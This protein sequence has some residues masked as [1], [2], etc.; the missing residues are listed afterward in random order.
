MS[1][2]FHNYWFIAFI[3]VDDKLHIWR[4]DF[5]T[6]YDAN[7]FCK[8]AYEAKGLPYVIVG[9]DTLSDANYAHI[10]AEAMKLTGDTRF[11]QRADHTLPSEPIT[12]P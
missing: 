1:N 2:Q 5:K 3:G 8:A 7:N 12:S 10:K 4:S 6:E 9:V 11:A